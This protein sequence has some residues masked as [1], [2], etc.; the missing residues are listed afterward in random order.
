MEHLGDSDFKSKCLWFYICNQDCCGEVD[1]CKVLLRE[2]TAAQMPCT[3]MAVTAG[4]IIAPVGRAT[5][6]PA[7]TWPSQCVLHH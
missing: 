5:A 3:A 2:L 4:D 6:M 1:G 7:A